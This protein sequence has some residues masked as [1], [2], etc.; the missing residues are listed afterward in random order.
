MKAYA[1]I[2]TALAASFLTAGCDNIL[3][4]DNYDEPQ[5]ILSGQV[6]FD[7]QPAGIRTSAIQLQLWQ[8][9]PGYQIVDFIPIYVNQ[10]GFFSTKIFNGNY[11]LALAP[12]NGPWVSNTTRI[13]LAV[14]GN[15]TINVPVQPYYTITEPRITHNPAVNQPYGAITATFKVGQINT[16][17]AL[18]FV[19][20]YIGLTRFVD[21]S[22]NTIS[23][24]NAV[25]ERSRA[26][27]LPQLN[28]N[29]DITITINLPNTIHNTQS[30]DRRNFVFVRIG[31]KTV[32]VA[33]LWYT[34][35]QEIAI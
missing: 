17:N 27:I 15:T 12:N 28:A 3:G 14:N 35:V 1:L 13:P 22:P 9:D 5:T 23:I 2:G 24:T 20:V 10:E 18:E 11:E 34:P 16:A 8:T 32:G 26:Q 6:T 4:G 33:E 30:P 7:G 21:R 25:R 29:G 19:G 31:V